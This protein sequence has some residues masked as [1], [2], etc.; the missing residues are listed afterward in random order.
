M[1]LPC[2][3]P[4]SCEELLQSVAAAQTALSRIL[5]AEGER[6]KG[7]IASTDDAGELLEANRAVNRTLDDV[8]CKERALE[9]E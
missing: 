6:L 7:I 3:E 9:R 1:P 8:I 4:R 5:S 2:P